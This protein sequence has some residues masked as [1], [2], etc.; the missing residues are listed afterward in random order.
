M[1]QPQTSIMYWSFLYVKLTSTP[2]CDFVF[3]CLL[4]HQT[5]YQPHKKQTQKEEMVGLLGFLYNVQ[6]VSI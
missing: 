3:Q 5:E 2:V 4:L 1:Q 6:P